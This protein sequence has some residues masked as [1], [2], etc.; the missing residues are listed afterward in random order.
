MARY[1]LNN[2]LLNRPIKYQQ[3]LDGYLTREERLKKFAEKKGVT[4]Y[5]AEIEQQRAETAAQDATSTTGMDV[6]PEEKNN[7]V[8]SP[9]SDTFKYDTKGIPGFDLLKRAPIMTNVDN[10]S[11]ELMANITG[12]I[13]GSTEKGEAR[14][15]KAFATTGLVA[16]GLGDILRGYQKGTGVYDDLYSFKKESDEEEETT[17]TETTDTE[18]TDTETTTTT[19]TN[20][21]NGGTFKYQN[22]ED[23]E[24]EEITNVNPFVNYKELD[25]A[26]QNIE[27]GTQD[28]KFKFGDDSRRGIKNAARLKG[29]SETL[30]NIQSEYA[31]PNNDGEGGN[32]GLDVVTEGDDAQGLQL[33][34]NNPAF[35]RSDRRLI[36]KLDRKSDLDILG[37]N[38]GSIDLSNANLL[39]QK[40]LTES[41][42][43]VGSAVGRLY[44]TDRRDDLTKKQRNIDI[45]AS[46]VALGANTALSGLNMTEEILGPLSAAK[47]SRYMAEQANKQYRSGDIN[48]FQEDD[49]GDVLYDQYL[50]DAGLYF[51][52]NGGEIM[53][54]PEGVFASKDKPV[55]VPGNIITMEGVRGKILAI[56]LDA[57]DNPTEEMTILNPGEKRVV[58]EKSDKVLEIPLYTE[59]GREMI[60]DVITK[61]YK[62]SKGGKHRTQ[63]SLDK[64]TKQKWRTPSGKKSS[65]TGEVYIP[66]RTVRKLKSTA[67]GRRKL[68]IANRKKRK[69]TSKGKQH[70][71]HGL[72]KGKNRSLLNGGTMMSQMFPALSC[73]QQMQK[74][75]AFTEG[76]SNY[77]KNNI[78]DDFLK[79]TPPPK[80]VMDIEIITLNKKNA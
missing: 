10:I 75:T 14:A 43:G 37:G 50:K 15:A 46:A 18:V 38:E 8:Y 3:T 4:D 31:G 1:H 13:F 17:D 76:L 57:Q 68:A 35:S 56:G 26:I 79:L 67:K 49:E 45:G 61:K 25:Q 27:G 80:V 51:A 28:F 36:R 5:L 11:T 30:G 66:E 73:A 41:L 22:S 47:R 55:I 19:T 54:S 12:N 78:G 24:E 63:R 44:D 62:Y 48:Y 42:E 64:W 65:E 74:N 7:L 29:L 59:G 23:E 21:L 70:A 2:F 53:T 40:G 77:I 58:F 32:L 72:H 71:R 9:E 20:K 52:K 16:K 39:E 60:K 33:D 69:A 6:V 34:L